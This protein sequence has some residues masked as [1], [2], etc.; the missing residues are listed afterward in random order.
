MRGDTLEEEVA[1]V[2]S[3]VDTLISKYDARIVASVLTKR[4]AFLWNAIFQRKCLSAAQRAKIV[5]DF[6][7]TVKAKPRS[8]AT[9]QSRRTLQ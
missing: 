3:E 4:A 2:A 6:A 5:N 8:S 7:R 1:T 9:A